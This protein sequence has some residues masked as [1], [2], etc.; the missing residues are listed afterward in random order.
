MIKSSSNTETN[1]NPKIQLR[2]NKHQN[3]LAELKINDRNTHHMPAG[4]TLFR[5][6]D[7]GRNSGCD[8]GV[9]PMMTNMEI[10]T[11]FQV[12]FQSNPPEMAGD[13]APL[14]QHCY[15]YS[16]SSSG[17]WVREFGFNVI[18][19]KSNFLSLGVHFF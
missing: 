16:Y 3:S 2:K 19:F 4:H 11:I 5:M 8:F 6:T 1:S 10:C 13:S 17:F 7:I 18:I 15:S 12:A 14:R 9:T